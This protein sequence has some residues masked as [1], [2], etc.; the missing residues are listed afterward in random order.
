M[1]TRVKTTITKKGKR[2]NGMEILK[3]SKNKLLFISIAVLFLVSCDRNKIYE[4]YKSIP[5]GVWSAKAPVTFDFEVKDTNQYCNLLVN[6]RCSDNYPY[7][8][9]YM[10]MTTKRPDGSMSIDTLEFYLLDIKGKPLGDCSG[11]VCNNRF[12]IDHDF[13]FPQPGKYE[14][15]LKQAMRTEDGNLPLVMD[16]G[17]R[18][19]KSTKKQQ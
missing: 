15:E 2:K 14:F 11:D 17:M 12:M 3:R 18:L 9:L 5:N 7:R 6:I 8:N 4:K 19:E 10:F 13:K 16:V 1:P